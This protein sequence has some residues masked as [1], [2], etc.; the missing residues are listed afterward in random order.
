MI[1]MAVNFG[2]VYTYKSFTKIRNGLKKNKIVNIHN[3]TGILRL[4][5]DT[6]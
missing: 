6:G 4:Y 3:Q 5:E 1:M 2:D